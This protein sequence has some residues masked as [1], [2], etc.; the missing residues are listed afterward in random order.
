[1]KEY[2]TST[3]RNIALVSHSSAGKTI[4]TEA[5][6][7]TT[8]ATTR[9]GTINEGT[10]VSDFDDEEI[11][12]GISLYS[13]VIPIEYKDN[14]I[15]FLDT[16]G[17]TDFVGEMI[18]ALSVVEGAVVVVDA[19]SGYE[20]GTEIAWN[21]CDKFNLPR[22][23]LINKMDRDN[24]DFN[25]A[26]ATIE[27]RSSTRLIK[28]QLPWGEKQDF[29]GVIDLL[30][31]KAYRGEG[32][33]PE[34]IP[35]EFQSAAE[36]G[37]MELVEAAAEGD[38]SLL[39]K[40]LESGELSPDEIINGLTAVVRKGDFIPVFVSAAEKEIGIFPLLDAII[41][42]FP[43]PDQQTDRMADGATGE[44][45]L[46]AVDS[47]PLAAY[48][49][50]TTADPFVG[51]Q[52]YFR[53]FSGMVNA[54]SRVWN[55]NK[56]TEERLGNIYIPRGKENM[57][58]KVVHS[59]DIGVC[60]KLTVT[61]TGNT[62]CDKG[63]P[64]KVRIPEYPNSLFQVALFPKTQADSTKISPAMTRLCEED[65]TLSWHQEPSTNQTILQGMGDQHIDVAIRRAESKFQVGLEIAIPKVPYKETITKKASAM[66][67]HKKQSGGAGQFG[68]VH[69]RV[70]PLEGDS[71]EFAN[72][73]FGGAISSSYM[74]AIE[75]GIRNVMKEGIIAGY[76]VTGIRVEVF[77]GKEHPVDSKPIAFEIAGREAFKLA[78]KDATPVLM[79]P[80]MV[81]K[82][83]VPEENMG[84]ILGDMNTRRA[85]VQ[86]MD[87]DKGQSTVTAN[88][89]LSEMQRY[90]T[91]LRS[92]TGGRGIFS[93]EFSHYETVPS[94][95]TNEIVEKKAKE[96]AAKE[97]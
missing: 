65:M 38:D 78:F 31:M 93:M 67:R 20:V 8:G 45:A 2:S 85:R 56:E 73:I 18:S 91:D 94:H 79:E 1:M 90:T 55:I 84:D 9:M 34:A 4:L 66:Y 16:P 35:A 63:H 70:E 71:F 46:K 60:P 57:Q 52:T 97:G 44:E 86:G 28:I 48:V 12:R 24:A 10:T 75:K 77:D 51:K 69:L 33:T 53:V 74:P 43:S 22:F 61:A 29:Q 59:G 42:I 49:W 96:D 17:Y 30:S 13:S 62:L 6:L 19:V 54:D 88:V 40:Y 5:F 32:K 87:T 36:E 3:I 37:H 89:P 72:A 27:E 68:E 95:I 15:N 76:T 11:R 58:V 26:L 21:Y 92:I 39:E 41:K 14:K 47:E 82:V 80:I 50:K 81:V 64:I 25:K 23:A 7:H 83:I